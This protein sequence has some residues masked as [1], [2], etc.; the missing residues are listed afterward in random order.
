L[1]DGEGVHG[2]DTPAGPGPFPRNQDGAVCD[3]LIAP[4]TLDAFVVDAGDGQA[5]DELRV[6]RKQLDTASGAALLP[7]RPQ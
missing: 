2:G 5:G 3:E 7:G 1:A 4:G 6:S